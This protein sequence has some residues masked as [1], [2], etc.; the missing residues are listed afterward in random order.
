[1]R[2]ILLIIFRLIFLVQ[3]LPTPA[4]AQDIKGA[5]AKC[6][7][8][9]FKENTKDHTECVKQV[10]QSAGSKMTPQSTSPLK[11]NVA[12]SQLQTEEEYWKYVNKIDNKEAF[13]AYVNKYPMGRYVELAR[14]QLI[15]LSGSVDQQRRDTEALEKERAN[16]EDAQRQASEEVAKRATVEAALQRQRLATEAAQKQASDEIKK[17]LDAEAALERAR[18]AKDFSQ[19]QAPSSSSQTPTSVSGPSQMTYCVST[20]R[21]YM[22][23]SKLC[24]G[25]VTDQYQA[26]SSSSQTPTSVSGPSQM[27]YCVSTN[28][29]YMGDSKLCPGAATDQYQATSNSSQTPTSVSG[30]SQMTYCASTNRYYMGDSKLCPGN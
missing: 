14:A 25:A 7:Q 17:R 20:N 4:Q 8:F 10:L 11:P 29:Y 27:T 13:Q 2:S 1:M 12:Q 19:R 24:P 18:V 16:R 9:G 22:G 21:Y 28:R 15:R 26:P 5:S 23:D 3:V 6:V 30:P